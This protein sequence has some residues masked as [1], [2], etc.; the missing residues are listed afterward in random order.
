MSAASVRAWLAEHAPDIALIDQGVSTATVAEAALALGTVSAE[1]FD[2]WVRPEDM[3][4]S[5]KA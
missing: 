1:Q 5:L 2:A 4:G 3:T